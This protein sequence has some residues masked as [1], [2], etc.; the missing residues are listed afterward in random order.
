M[1]PKYLTIFAVMAVLFSG[2]VM[3]TT[4]VMALEN[5]AADMMAPSKQI[6]EG[7]SIHDIKCNLGLTLVIKMSDNSPACVKPL[8]ADKL[9]ARGWAVNHNTMSANPSGSNSSAKIMN[10]D[11][12]KN[13]NHKMKNTMDNV[14]YSKAPGLVG[15][16]GYFNTTPEKLS[17]DMKGKVIL[18]Q[19][20]TFD[21]I[22]CI[23][24]LPHIVDLESKYGDKGLLIIGI[25]S[26]ETI[27]EKDPQNV[28]DAIEKYGIKYPVVLDTNYQTWNAFG[29]HYWPREYVVDPN[30]NIRFDHIGEGAYDDM[31]KEIQ[32]LLAENS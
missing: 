12:M 17:N 25:H 29:N 22:N 2:F 9:I 14:Q 11:S 32:T 30:G 19:F 4:N 16:T 1:N 31:E 8:T 6:L 10:S 13:P 26:P 23:H 5:T 21:C 27:F 3:S 28:Q 18:Y 24:T 15:I 7:V 20:W